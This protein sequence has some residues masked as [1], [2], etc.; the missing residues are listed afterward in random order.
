MG[1]F[2]ENWQIVLFASFISLLSAYFLNKI[3]A[4]DNHIENAAS[5][6]YVDNGD[7]ELKLQIDKKVNKT[8]F[9]EMND[10][11]KVMDERIYDLW[12]ERKK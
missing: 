1:K 11:Q 2:K 5:I 3:Q 8:D 4:R 7:N 6:E 12:K 9:D 10:R